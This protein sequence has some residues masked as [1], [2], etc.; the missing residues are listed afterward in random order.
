MSEKETPQ[1]FEE[2]LSDFINTFGKKIEWA[3]EG[4]FIVQFN[5]VETPAQAD[6]LIKEIDRIFT[7]KEIP[8]EIFDWSKIDDDI[9]SFLIKIKSKSLPKKPVVIFDFTKSKKEERDYCE[10]SLNLRDVLMGFLNGIIIINLP[11]DKAR[12][13][14]LLPDIFTVR[15]FGINPD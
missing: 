11:K 2:K 3:E 5:T 7:L 6:T 12:L 14:G 15:D 9:A 10:S 13:R 1:L 8:V 4:S